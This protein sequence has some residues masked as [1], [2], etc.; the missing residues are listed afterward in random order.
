VRSIRGEH[1]AGATISS[2]IVRAPALRPHEEERNGPPHPDPES[3]LFRAGSTA[4]CPQ[5]RH[6]I[7]LRGRPPLPLHDARRLRPGSSPA[8]LSSRYVANGIRICPTA[9]MKR[10]SPTGGPAVTRSISSLHTRSEPA[11]QSPTPEHK[12]RSDGGWQVTGGLFECSKSLY[13]NVLN[14]WRGIRRPAARHKM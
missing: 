9:L 2:H 13:I 14:D 6:R 10:S 11:S 3:H 8:L 7:H 4:P 12:F 5:Q 1:A